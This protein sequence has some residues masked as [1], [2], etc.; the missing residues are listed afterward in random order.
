VRKIISSGSY[1]VLLLSLLFA[2]CSQSDAPPQEPTPTVSP[3]RGSVLSQP[4]AATD[5]TLTDQH[6]QPFRLSEQRGKVVLLFFGYTSCPDVC[7]TTLSAWKRVHEEL[8]DEAERV[9]FVFVTVDPERD[10]P[11]RLGLHV[12][13]FNP[14]F[15]PVQGGFV[16]LTGTPD[17]LEPIYEAY[18]VYY[19]KVETPGSALGYLVNHTSSGYVIDPQGNWRLRHAF[20][21]VSADIAYDIRE[22]LKGD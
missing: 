3:F 7:P 1:V 5:F 12:D 19:E 16:A 8:G 15:V 6:G 13:L 20:G 22:L 14:D 11:E 4:I 10:T 9:R 17:E 18:G 2:S 21:T